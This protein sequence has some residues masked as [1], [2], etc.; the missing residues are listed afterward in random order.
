MAVSK[1]KRS[2]HLAQPQRQPQH[3]KSA[4]TAIPDRAKAAQS[5]SPGVGGPEPQRLRPRLNRNS[6]ELQPVKS[7]VYRAIADMNG[8]FEHALQGLQ[9]LQENSFLCVGSL[10]GMRNLIGRLRAQANHELMAIL[11]EREKANAGHYLRRS[12]EQENSQAQRIS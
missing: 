2:I 6:T 11:G 5:G 7:H 4:R 12:M 9:V 1:A 10:K 8:G 3:A